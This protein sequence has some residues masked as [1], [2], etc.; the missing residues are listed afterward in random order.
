[1]PSLVTGRPTALGRGRPG[2]PVRDPGPASRGGI[3]FPAK[4]FAG[5]PLR[6]YDPATEQ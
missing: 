4:G 3:A 6:L 1:M 2:T 5:L